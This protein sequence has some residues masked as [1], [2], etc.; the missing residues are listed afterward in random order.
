MQ[1]YATLCKLISFWNMA[2]GDK[3]IRIEDEVDR[4]TDLPVN[5]KEHILD[6]LSTKEAV[7]TSVLSS[8]WRCCWT[9]LRKLKFNK[10]FWTYAGDLKLLEHARIIDRVLM[11]HSGP[12]R[13]FMLHIPD[14]RRKTLDINMWLRVLSNNGVQAIEID[15]HQYKDMQ[16][17]GPFPM[18]SCLFQ[19]RELESL[20]LCNCKL[21]LP[22]DFKSFANL[23]SLCLESVEIEPCVLGSLIS[24]CLLLESLSLKDSYLQE[25]LTIEALNLKTFYFDDSELQ[26]I[27]FKDIPKLEC[28]SL[29]ATNENVKIDTPQLYNTL[30]VLSSLSGIKELTFDFLLLE[31]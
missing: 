21:T 15:A 8:K 1:K 26:N 23:T 19:C 24:E 13:E 25:P 2:G 11:L 6:C 5:I 31:V 27:I 28:V 29:S 10:G 20:S 30:D 4:I 17:D 14:F 3:R 22:N 12:I 18:P 16:T 7:A 9:G